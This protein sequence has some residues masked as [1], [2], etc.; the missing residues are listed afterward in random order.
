MT[1]E[2][3]EACGEAYVIRALTSPADDAR[4]HVGPGDDAAVLA[5]GTVLT[6][7]ALVEGVHWDHRHSAEDVGAR[8]VAV[9]ASDVAAMGARPSWALLTL[10]L[11][12][13]LDRAWVD[14][15]ARGLQGALR[16]LGIPLL[17]GDTTRSPLGVHASL[18]MAGWLVA[19][20]LLRAGAGPDE[21]IWV[22]GTLGDA[23]GGFSL[24]DPPAPLLDALRRPAPPLDL[25]P[26]LAEAGL[27]T[28]A[29]DL[30]DGLA[31]DLPR[32]CRAS[33][34]GAVVDPDALPISAALS[35]AI[36]DPI[37]LAAGFGDDYTLLFTASPAH[38]ARVRDLGQR[39]GVRLSRVGRTTRAPA[40]ILQ[41]RPWPAGWQ[42]FEGAG[43]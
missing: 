15:F 13:P 2:P 35:S 6:A 38:A 33:G 27:A 3:D 37:D 40:V 23:G 39:L 16:A 1:D 18:T 19:A 31:T 9:N 30:S 24:P 36:P 29:M 22:S 43:A 28:A 10:S 32:L 41:G 4:V 11:P 7:D 42:H 34:V 26:A 12:V 17:G 21:D 20:P 25:G 14:G 8:L 5:D